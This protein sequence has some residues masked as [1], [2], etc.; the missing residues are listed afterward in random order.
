MYHGTRE[1]ITDWF[2]SLGYKYDA[3]LAG[4]PSDW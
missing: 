3:S 2:S 1:G 4:V